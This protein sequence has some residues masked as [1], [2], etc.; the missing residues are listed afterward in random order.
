MKGEEPDRPGFYFRRGGDEYRRH[1]R[2]RLRA[3]PRVLRVPGGHGLLR[4]PLPRF[5]KTLTTEPDCFSYLH[6]RE[7]RR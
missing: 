3:E 5:E 1:I 7:G 6:N 2:G 4:E